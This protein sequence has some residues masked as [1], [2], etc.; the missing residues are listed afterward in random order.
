MLHRHKFSGQ[1]ALDF[2]NARARQPE[3]VR[4][5]QKDSRYT[6]EL[7]EDLSDLLRLSGSRSWIKYHQLCKLFAEITYHGFASINNL[8][9]L[10]EEYTGTI[11]VDSAYM[12]IPSRLLQLVS[13][14]LEFGGDAL[15]LR[16]LQ[17]LEKSIRDN[18]EMVPEAK[19]KLLTAIHVM[20]SSPQ[21]IKALHKSLFYLR[22]NKYQISKR[23]TGINYVLI[24]HWL[25][26]DFSLYGYKLLGVVTFLQVTLSLVINAYEAWKEHRRKQKEVVTNTTRPLLSTDQGIEERKKSDAPQ[27]ILCLEPRINTSLTPCGHLFCWNCL[28]DWLDERDECPLCRE[29]LKKSSIVQLQN[30]Q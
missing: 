10:G 3:I 14:I 26:P 21:Y 30:Y 7:A 12:N 27:C 23:F 11:Q 2:R 24:R 4:S 20:R 1:I 6:D 28:L 18:D 8:Q 9:T 13:I 29:K 16:I 17:K 5:V 19:Q 25:Q 22:S 15:Y